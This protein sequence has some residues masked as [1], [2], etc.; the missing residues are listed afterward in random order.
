MEG[1]TFTEAGN[2]VIASIFQ[3]QFSWLHCLA[4][5]SPL[6]EWMWTSPLFY[7]SRLTERVREMWSAVRRKSPPI[8]RRK[9]SSATQQVS[10]PSDKFTSSDVNEARDTLKRRKLNFLRHRHRQKRK[11]DEKQFSF[12]THAVIPEIFNRSRAWRKERNEFVGLGY[13]YSVS[14]CYLREITNRISFLLN[15]KRWG[16]VKPGDSAI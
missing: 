9:T 15:K 4:F 3:I 2:E 1:K 16:D 10:S 6:Q 5:F 11:A 13:F 8:R 7:Y 14:S 12:Y